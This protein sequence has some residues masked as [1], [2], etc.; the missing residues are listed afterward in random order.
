VNGASAARSRSDLDGV[1]RELIYWWNRHER[2][3]VMALH[4]VDYEGADVGCPAVHHG[5]E[6]AGDCF[7]RY[8]AA[9][10]DLRLMAEDQVA[11]GNRVAVSW[12][13]W[14]THEGTFMNIP[15]TGRRV[16]LRGV[17]FLTF[18]HNQVSRAS[19]VWDV[20]GFLRAVRLLPDL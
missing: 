10:P 8:W 16:R 13:A 1:L 7:G 12:H 18:D 4:A 14:G 20:A 5:R 9:F 11:E 2:E 3:R 15:A 17:S 19:H 6:A